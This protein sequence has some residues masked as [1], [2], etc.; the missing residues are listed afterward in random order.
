MNNILPAIFLGLIIVMTMGV[1][2]EL[3]MPY[4]TNDAIVASEALAGENDG[5]YTWPCPNENGW[6]KENI[7]LE[8][9]I[10]IEE[11]EDSMHDNRLRSGTRLVPVPINIVDPDSKYVRIV[12]EH[13]MDHTQGYSDRARA[14]A[15]L[16]FVNICISYEYDTTLFNATEFW[17]TPLE[18]LFLKRGDC[19]DTSILLCSILLAM[20]LDAALL[21]FDQ[22]IAVGL[23]LDSSDD[24]VFCETASDARQTLGS[25]AQYYED[26]MPGIYRYGETNLCLLALNNSLAVYYETFSDMINRK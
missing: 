18:T 13:I 24:Y 19:E 3:I 22:H 2:L 5:Q 1:A 7:T 4:D 20:G 17:A 12:A 26:E 16:W 21:D 6:F 8:M 11:F 14:Q 15:A 25:G 9:P 10:S 23:Y